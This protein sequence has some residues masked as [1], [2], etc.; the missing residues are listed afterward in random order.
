MNHLRIFAIL[1]LALASF[2]AASQDWSTITIDPHRAYKILHEDSLVDIFGKG[3]GKPE[4]QKINA[5]LRLDKNPIEAHKMDFANAE[6]SGDTLRISI[7]G[8]PGHF[9]QSYKISILHNM[10]RSTFQLGT[11]MD[12]L[13]GGPP[14]ITT[15]KSSLVLNTIRL[16]K[17]KVIKG[18]TE[19]EGRCDSCD[20]SFK[21]IR[22]K[23]SFKVKVK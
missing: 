13:E 17:G 10:Q 15:V 21:T 1:L 11:D 7:I 4:Y 19:Y 3:A 5:D 22:I 23:G 2:T 12:D 8:Y 9:W 20:E 16:K 18:F 6:L 14:N